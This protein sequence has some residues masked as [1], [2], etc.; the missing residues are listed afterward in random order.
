MWYRVIFEE[1][2]WHYN[3]G[4]GF[5]TTLQPRYNAHD[6]SQAKRAL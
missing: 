2:I 6:G 3:K 1:V 4:L 5:R